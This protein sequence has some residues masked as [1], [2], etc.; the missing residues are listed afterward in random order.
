MSSITPASASST[1]AGLT[2]KQ[3]HFRWLIT[4]AIACGAIVV[5]F[6]FFWMAVT[7]LKTAPEIQRVPLQIT[8]DNWLNFSNYAEVFKREPFLRYLL[9]SRYC[10]VDR[11]SNIAVELFGH[12]KPG[13]RRVQAICGWVNWKVAF[14]YHH[15]RSSKTALDVFT[16]RTGVCRDFQHLALE[17]IGLLRV[18]PATGNEHQRQQWDGCAHAAFCL[19]PNICGK[20]QNGS[21]ITGLVSLGLP[22]DGNHRCLKEEGLQPGP[23]EGVGAA[24]MTNTLASYEDTGIVLDPVRGSSVGLGSRLRS[25]TP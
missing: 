14:G 22:V 4:L 8:P 6:P 25:S 17:Q 18:R 13:W 7:S 1:R 3:A 11:L 2:L 20:V 12:L 10:E 24:L 19:P 9:N 16:E 15:A 5:F 23:V 21:G